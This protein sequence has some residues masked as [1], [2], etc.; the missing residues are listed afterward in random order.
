MEIEE[1]ISHA[2]E[3]A[4][5]QRE[6][7]NNITTIPSHKVICNTCAEEHEQLAEWLEEL[8]A[9]R[10]KELKHIH[11]ILPPVANCTLFNVEKLTEQFK[12]GGE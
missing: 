10:E 5:L 1:A 12:E 9:Y 3:V 7:A 11:D 4:E 2:R 6:K 8:K